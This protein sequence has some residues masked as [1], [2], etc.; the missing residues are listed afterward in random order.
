MNHTQLTKHNHILQ[1]NN[2]SH[3]Q[4]NHEHSRTITA[5]RYTKNLSEEHHLT[6]LDRKRK[7]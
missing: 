5:N 1:V 2:N 4:V 6:Q 7:Y 3:L